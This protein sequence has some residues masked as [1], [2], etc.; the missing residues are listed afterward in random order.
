MLVLTRQQKRVTLHRKSANKGVAG[1]ASVELARAISMS[2]QSVAVIGA[3][4]DRSKFSNKAIRAYIHQG[5]DVYPVNPKGGEIEGL[6]VYT[7]LGEIPVKV[8]RVTVYVPPQVGIT[9]LPG[10]ARAQ[11]GELWVNPGAE[12]DELIEE[13]HKL[14]LNPIVACSILG[15]GVKPSEFSD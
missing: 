15:V 13:A 6:K 1:A 5:W 8:D 9:L 2:Q 7:S 11:P 14:G 4:N 3:S 10:I 12:S